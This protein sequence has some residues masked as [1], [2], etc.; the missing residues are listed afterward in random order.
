MGVLPLLFAEGMTW[1][2]L[3][4]KGD[5]TVSLKGLAEIKPMQWLEA[6]IT[7]A[8]GEKRA[9]PLRAAID[10]FDELD[11]FRNGGILHYVLR[12]LARARCL[13]ATARSPSRSAGC[14]KHSHSVV[15]RVNAFLPEISA[16]FLHAS[17]A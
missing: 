17:A 11:Y 5:E 16:R 4:L 9:V 8:S 2:S 1:K 14:A 10:T 7:Y 6:D 12:S 15:T 13:R 3:E